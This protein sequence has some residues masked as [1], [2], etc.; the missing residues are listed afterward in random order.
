MENLDGKCRYNII[1][2]QYFR[3]NNFKCFILEINNNFII[4]IFKDTS[5]YIILLIKFSCSGLLTSFYKI[6][7]EWA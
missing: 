6:F 5:Y 2:L 1:F 7:Q 4:Y 3:Y